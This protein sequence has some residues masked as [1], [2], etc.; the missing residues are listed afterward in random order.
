MVNEYWRKKR[1]NDFFFF[2]RW[3]TL[4]L[5][6]IMKVEVIHLALTRSIQAGL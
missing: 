2:Y 3:N 6:K 4:F 1:L 5:K